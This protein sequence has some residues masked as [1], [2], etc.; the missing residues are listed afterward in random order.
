MV[1]PEVEQGSSGGTDGDLAGGPWLG[2]GTRAPVKG[3]D[4]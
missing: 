1:A 4:G 2:G 3:G